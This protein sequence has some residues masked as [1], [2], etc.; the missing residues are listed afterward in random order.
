MVKARS[1]AGRRSDDLIVG[2]GECALSDALSY[3]ITGYE[4][5]LICLGPNFT[6]LH[7]MIT[8]NN[9]H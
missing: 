4:K 5:R 2:L 3:L 6:H 7:L 8:A 9:R 1:V